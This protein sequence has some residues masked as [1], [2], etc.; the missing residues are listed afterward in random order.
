MQ[1]YVM[2]VATTSK[3]PIHK[4]VANKIRQVEG[5]GLIN[6]MAIGIEFES[7]MLVFHSVF[8]RPESTTMKSF[9]QKNKPIL[10]Y[11]REIKNQ[12]LMFK[13]LMWLSIKGSHAYYGIVENALI[14]LKRRFE[15][16]KEYVNVIKTN[17]D[18]GLNCTEYGL[19]FLS[20][21]FPDEFT[22]ERN[23]DSLGLREA[24][25]ACN[26]NLLLLRQDEINAITVF[27]ESKS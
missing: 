15:Q 22:I 17:H 20:W 2:F 25:D 23:E 18:Q 16:L 19:K 10:I 11:K 7:E 5:L 24:V 9:L 8:P 13:M 21:A 14:Y 6:H 27:Y 12:L 26:K 1:I 3:N 4:F